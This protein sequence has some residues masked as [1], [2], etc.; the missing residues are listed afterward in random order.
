AGH[1]SMF[2]TLVVLAYYAVISGWVLHFFMQLAFS[3]FNPSHFQPEG[4]LKVLLDNGWLQL[5]LTSAHLL[6]VAVIV[7][8]D[9]EYGLEKWVGYCMS[10]FVVLLI[11]LA[12][13]SLSLK[14]ANEAMRF[15]FY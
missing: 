13:Q 9:M 10:I 4:A 8:K 12:V 14:S 5:L 3:V 2:I 1:L 6:T 15:L 7:A 11:A